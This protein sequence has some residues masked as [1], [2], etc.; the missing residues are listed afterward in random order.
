MS[1]G[2]VAAGAA[3]GLTTRGFAAVNV[4]LVLVWMGVLV[5]LGREHRRRAREGGAAP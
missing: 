2:L 5:L 1:A 3:V 4:G